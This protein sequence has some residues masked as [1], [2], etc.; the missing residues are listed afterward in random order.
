[1]LKKSMIE[2][3]FLIPRCDDVYTLHA[4]LSDRI[5]HHRDKEKYL[6]ASSSVGNETVVSVLHENPIKGMPGTEVKGSETGDVVKFRLRVNATKKG[7]NN[8]LLPI[9]RADIHA[10]LQR[11]ISGAEIEQCVVLSARA[12]PFVKKGEAQYFSVVELEGVVRVTSG[13]LFNQSVASGVGRRRCCGFG[14]VALEGTKAF[15]ILSL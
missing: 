3:T 11:Q 14:L 6:F 1:M 13:E 8:K 15:K 12:V 2:T 9:P 4:W 5:G 7:L 10:W